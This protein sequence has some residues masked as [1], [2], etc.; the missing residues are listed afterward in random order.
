MT[1]EKAQEIA[2]MRYS[3]IAPLISGLQDNYSS[4]EAFFRDAAAKGITTPSGL[5]KHYAPTTIKK[6]YNNYNRDGFDALVP[7]SRADLGKPRK[8]DDELKEQIQ[9]LKS[10][11]P[12]ISAAAIHRQLQDNG[13]IKP[14]ELSE[15]TVNRYLNTLAF[16]MKTTTNQDMRRYERPHINEVWC[17]DS[18]VGPYLKTD[19]G[20][21]HRIHIMALIDDASR[22]IVGID[23]FFNDNFVNLMS[24]MK[25]AVAKYGRPQMFNFD[26]GSAYKN[27]QMELLA[28]RLGSVI[29]YDRPYTPTQ[30]AK[31]ERWF[32]TCKDQWMATLDIREFHSLDELRGNLLAYVNQYNQSVH[33][34]LKGKSPQDR[35]F[36]ESQL[37]HRLSEEEIHQSFLL[38]IER[39]VSA[40][41]VITID[42]VEYEVDYRFAKQR[43]RLRYS[44]DMKEIFIVENDGS[45]SPIRILN[46][47]ENAFVKREKIHLCRGE[48]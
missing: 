44:P 5:V 17:G 22:F 37:I 34:S 36:S 19:D 42:Q 40:D 33:S 4:N 31:I 14:D 26:N 11:Y 32:R 18:S 16:E 7:S 46:K 47:L 29:H 6:W 10:N 38:E 25:S 2:L 12:R 3:I 48:E 35:F 15:S 13:S 21:K 23:V 30:K 41:S 39:R 28:A 43:I 27:K 24:V 20:K 1:Q 8:L 9:Y 45:L